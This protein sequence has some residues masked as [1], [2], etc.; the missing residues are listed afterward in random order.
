MREL[1]TTMQS[2]RLT[3]TLPALPLLRKGRAE[4][5]PPHRRS[6]KTN[7]SWLSPAEHCGCFAYHGIQRHFENGYA[8]FC[9]HFHALIHT[10]FRSLRSTLCLHFDWP[11]QEK[12]WILTVVEV[13][14]AELR[15]HY[16]NHSLWVKHRRAID[17][18]RPA[19]SEIMGSARLRL[20]RSQARA[21]RESGRHIRRESPA[22]PG[23]AGRSHRPT[24]L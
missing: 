9:Q 8:D 18:H 20:R 24:P 21:P 19:P 1:H 17:Q 10:Y 11:V 2:P 22:L 13:E 4:F 6:G 7:I 16:T 14:P 3:T 5:P 15:F 12:G 23:N